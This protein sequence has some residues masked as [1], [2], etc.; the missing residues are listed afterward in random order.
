MKSHK[1]NES[2]TWMLFFRKEGKLYNNTKPL[3]SLGITKI[4]FPY[5]LFWKFLKTKV[6]AQS[7][8]TLIYEKKNKKKAKN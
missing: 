5:I 4:L 1:E 2:H 6:T 8:G 7:V 3:K